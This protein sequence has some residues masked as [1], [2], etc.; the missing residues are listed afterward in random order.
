[1][2]PRPK[3]RPSLDGWLRRSRCSP[4]LLSLTNK[5]ALRL[6]TLMGQARRGGWHALRVYF[7]GRVPEAA[8]LKR[9]ADRAIVAQVVAAR[10]ELEARGT[11]WMHH[12]LWRQRV[13]Y[14]K[15]RVAAR[16]V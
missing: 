12:R 2:A 5:L 7:L 9:L 4:A 14:A 11:E 10:L 15:A 16:R 3:Y 6:R 1:M 8:M 13:L